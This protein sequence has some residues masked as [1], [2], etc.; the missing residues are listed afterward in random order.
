M[1]WRAG[2][3]D[4]RVLLLGGS[5]FIGRWVARHLAAAGA[6]LHL[7][8]RDPARA[9]A[10]WAGLG[11]RG[12]P[13]TAD[14]SRPGIAAEIVQAARP[15]ITFNL[16]GYG[17][18]PLERDAARAER[19]NHRLVAEL[20]RAAGGQR[21]PEWAGQ[22]LVHAGSAAEYGAA[23]GTLAEDTHPQPTSLYGRTKL[24]GTEAVVAATGEG[25][26]RGVAAR[27][28]TVYGPGERA[29]RLLPSLIE[30]ARSR[31]ELPLTAGTQRRDFTYVE[32]VA[33]GLLRLGA[34]AE[35]T[36]TPVNLATG[37]LETVRRFA[38]RAAVV[39][40]LPVERLRFGVLPGRQDEMVHEEVSVVRLRELCGWLPG[41]SIEEGVRRTIETA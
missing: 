24:A 11:I 34:L 6:D 7:V 12:A 13:I 9:E 41:T 18:D 16:A 36:E 28:F 26:L 35:S 2:Y 21:D 30:A 25:L 37:R 3:R 38:E 33:E 32:D 27:L 39:L 8:A 17:I 23:G 14:L 4:R 15:C 22:D 10:L 31:T 29:G 19:I 20:A 5:G 40:G 1:T